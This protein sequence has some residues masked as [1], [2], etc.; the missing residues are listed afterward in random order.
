M[1]SEHAA[2]GTRAEPHKIAALFAKYETIAV[3][4]GD[5]QL[6]RTAIVEHSETAHLVSVPGWHVWE[7]DGFGNVKRSRAIF[8][9]A[10]FKRQI[11]GK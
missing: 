7:L 9:V 10:D 5:L 1:A 8:D 6:G 2:A 3:N 11:A 4:G